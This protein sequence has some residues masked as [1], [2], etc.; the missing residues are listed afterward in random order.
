M[1]ASDS[2]ASSFTNTF[3]KTP[4]SV[5]SGAQ[6]FELTGFRLY[7]LTLTV[8]A[9]VV[10]LL[11]ACSVAGTSDVE[12]ISFTNVDQGFQSGVQERKFFVIKREK[13]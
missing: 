5:H 2:F 1:T 4:C 10:V 3:S 8:L 13:E 6:P 9:V 11:A 12:R 7:A